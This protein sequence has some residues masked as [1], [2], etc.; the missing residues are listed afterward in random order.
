MRREEDKIGALGAPNKR[1]ISVSGI[2][3][4]NPAGVIN[5]V[6]FKHL[7][8]IVTEVPVGE[9]FE[10]WASVTV[11]N[12]DGLFHTWDMLCTCK[13]TDGLIAVFDKSWGDGDEQSDT[14]MHLNSLPSGY[15]APVM[16]DHDLSLIFT[17]W[18]NETRGETPP[19]VSEW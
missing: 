5:D 12:P 14:A 10:I 8:Q 6:W 11:S 4:A 13:S 3:Q 17:I 9:R 19:P 1:R 18:K 15:Q 7:G 16:P 2:R